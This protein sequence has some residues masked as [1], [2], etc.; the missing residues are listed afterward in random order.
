LPLAAKRLLKKPPLKRLPLKQLLKKAPLKLLR[1][2]TRWP[3]A[4]KLLPTKL[5]L[6]LLKLLLRPQKLL[7]RPLKKPRS[8]SSLPETELKKERSFLTEGPLFLCAVD[9]RH[10]SR[11]VIARP[12]A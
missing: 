10:A 9:R 8:N 7:L 4:L 6:R 1:L 3:K 11:F 12:R 2:L 5:L